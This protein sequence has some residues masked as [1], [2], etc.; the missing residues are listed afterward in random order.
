[1][2]Q[3]PKI[4]VAGHRGMVG[5]AI[6]RQLLALVSSVTSS[7]DRDPPAVAALD[8][9]LAQVVLAS[10]MWCA[11][12]ADREADQTIGEIDRAAVQKYR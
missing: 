4:Y 7:A 9:G 3:H 11:W 5:S 10:V 6:V 8:R 12:G 1:M 2:T